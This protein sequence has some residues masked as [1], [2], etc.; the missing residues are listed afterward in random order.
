MRQGT[1]VENITVD[2]QLPG[3]FALSQNYPNPFNPTTH[4]EFALAQ[5]SQVSIDVYNILGR[6]VRCLVDE[7]LPAGNHRVTFDGRSSDSRPL[8]SGVYFY[9]ISAGDFV[10]SKKMLL[11]K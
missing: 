2:G 9:R 4:I 8:A 6:H 1:D 5:A 3:S 11:L 10:E 7:I